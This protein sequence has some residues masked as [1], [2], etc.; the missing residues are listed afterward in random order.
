LRPCGRVAIL[1]A[2]G[3]A[4][5]LRRA[6]AGLGLAPLLDAAIDRKGLPVVAL[7]WQKGDAAPTGAKR[8]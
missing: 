4:D 3:Q 8:G 7:A 6:A 1:A 5:G 2:A